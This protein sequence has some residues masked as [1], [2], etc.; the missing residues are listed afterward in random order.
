LDQ[1][2]V[3]GG[4]RGDPAKN[5]AEIRA[6][7][8][9]VQRQAPD[10]RTHSE[11][12]SLPKPIILEVCKENSIASVDEVKRKILSILTKP[13]IAFFPR[14]PAWH[15]LAWGTKSRPM[16]LFGEKNLFLPERTAQSVTIR[17]FSVRGMEGCVYG[18]SRV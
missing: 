16:I 18:K 2:P 6:G 5:H 13:K 9:E 12:R 11:R 17:H 15:G 4:S 1:R 14:V 8:N 7:V 3:G 10:L